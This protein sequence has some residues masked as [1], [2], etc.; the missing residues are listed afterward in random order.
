MT[1]RLSDCATNGAAL[2]SSSP[3]IWRE[4]R[5]RERQE[6]LFVG[7]EKKAEQFRARG[8]PASVW[9]QLDADIVH[10]ALLAREEIYRLPLTLFYLQQHSYKEI[11]ETLAIPMGTVMSRISRGKEQL[12]KALADTAGLTTEDL[13]GETHG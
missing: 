7:G 4:V 8:G 2:E 13:G 1:I 5:G 11:A 9:N 12:R 3:A 6:G 10:R